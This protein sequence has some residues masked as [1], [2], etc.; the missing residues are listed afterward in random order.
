MDADLMASSTSQVCYY[1]TCYFE[2]LKLQ[3][4]SIKL[5][6]KISLITAITW[7]WQPEDSTVDPYMICDF[8]LS[9]KNLR[10]TVFGFSVVV[11]AIQYAMCVI[12]TYDK[13][14]RI[15]LLR[16]TVRWQ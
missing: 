14:V 5:G 9:K 12:C 7:K 13:N 16:S 4:D 11:S 8:P 6:T 1:V 2:N 10:H 3:S 15:I